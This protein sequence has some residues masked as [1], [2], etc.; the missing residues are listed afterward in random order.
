MPE[1]G[2]SCIDGDIVYKDGVSTF[3]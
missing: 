1:N 2:K 3:L